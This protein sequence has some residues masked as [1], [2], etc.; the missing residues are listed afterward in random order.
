MGSDLGAKW[1]SKK[2]CECD[3]LCEP[4]LVRIERLWLKLEWSNNKR[5][6]IWNLLCFPVVGTY[7]I[8][9]RDLKQ[10]SWNKLSIES[11]KFL[12]IK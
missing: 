3:V 7:D 5:V 10:K 4:H 6:D 2:M 8:L 11:Q 1:N 9:V 12:N